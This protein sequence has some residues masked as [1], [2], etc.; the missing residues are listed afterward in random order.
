MIGYGVTIDAASDHVTIDESAIDPGS[1][2]G[3]GSAQ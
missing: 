1:F 2:I 3:A